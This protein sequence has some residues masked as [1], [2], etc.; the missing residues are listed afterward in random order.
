MSAT[1][2]LV[3]APRIAL[4][5]NP[6]CGKTAL[7]NALTGSR[8]KVANYPG[9][10]VERKVG[11]LVSPGGRRVQVVDLPGT[12]SLTAHSPDQAVTRDV[13]LGRFTHEAPPDVVVFVADATNLRLNLSLAL[14]LKRLG[15]P[16]IVALNMMDMAERRGCRIDTAALSAALGVPVVPTVAIRRDGIADLL[17]QIDTL[18]PALRQQAGG[19]D[20]V[21]PGPVELRGF[22]R[23]IDRILADALR[24]PGRPPELT[25]R[26][27][28]VLLH[29]LA[30]MLALLTVLFLVFQA[31]FAW[32][33]APMDLID[34]GMSGLQAH[35]GAAMADGPLKSLIVDGVI[36]GVGSV[37]IFLPQILIL[38]L[39]IQ[40]LEASGYMARAAF[41]LDRLMGG[42]GLHGRAFIP[43][44]SSFACAIPGIMAARTIE[45][46]AD[47][48][49]TIMIAPLMTCSARLPV[50]TL[51]IA[52]FIPAETV[53]GGF[54]GLQGLVMFALYAAGILAALAVA[55]V[56]KRTT[57]RGAREP[58]LME[59]P[60]YRWP[61]PRDVLLGLLERA[62]IFLVRAG[63]IIFA[64]M[65]L[66]WFLA[67]YPVPPDGATGPAIDYSF[68]GQIGKALAPLLAPIGFTWQIA[69][70][71]VP[72]MAAREVAV[73]A[74]GTVYALSETG[75][76][77]E[78]SLAST[79]AADWS[80]PTALALLAWFVFAPQC[81]STL[82]VVR[83]ET[84]SWLWPLAMFTYLLAL[85]YAASFVTFRVATALLGG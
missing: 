11:Q 7:F 20:W 18:A 82:G 4:V 19:C 57:L 1:T 73:A 36:A 69:I 29:P 52:A 58:L 66:L 10:T 3:G 60:A 12:Y 27:D 55:F 8:Q 23:E 71:L 41:L 72:G 35:V 37:V 28:R 79:L 2:A 62:R 30:G 15:R 6:N 26:V 5:G 83:R 53:L 70:A 64:I 45:N 21:E 44:L 32:A 67:S 59:L 33:A 43:L 48:L 34:A 46:R 16:L 84:N 77:L 50:Y 51:L 38:F 76:A 54:V 14:E 81:I 85:A 68:A 42:V 65:V 74:L 17:A 61:N 39:F 75:D 49:A 25:R 56:L 47:R 22:R 24:E 40:I 63:T 80:L 9:V 13:V 31:V 78:A